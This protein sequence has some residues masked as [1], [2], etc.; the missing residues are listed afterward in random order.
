MSKQ[1]LD[2]LSCLGVSDLVLKKFAPNFCLQIAQ[3]HFVVVAQLHEVT[4]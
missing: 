2:L 4:V 1:L 3:L